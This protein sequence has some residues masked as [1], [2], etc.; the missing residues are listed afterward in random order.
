MWLVEDGF[1]FGVRDGRFEVWESLDLGDFRGCL[2][3][4]WSGKVK[5]ILL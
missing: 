4:R 3:F 5:G 1:V 2:R